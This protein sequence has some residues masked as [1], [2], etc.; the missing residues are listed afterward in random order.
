[1]SRKTNTL[2]VFFIYLSIHFYSSSVFAEKCRDSEPLTW[3]SWTGNVLNKTCKGYE[4]VNIPGVEGFIFKTDNFDSGTN[5]TLVTHA[6]NMNATSKSFSDKKIKIEVINT[7]AYPSET[8]TFD[9]QIA[10]RIESDFIFSKFKVN[11]TAVAQRYEYIQENDTLIAEFPVETTIDTDIEW[12]NELFLLSPEAQFLNFDVNVLSEMCS[13]NSEIDYGD[14]D[15][16]PRC[17][18]RLSITNSD[19]VFASKTYRVDYF[20]DKNN[21]FR[22][23]VREVDTICTPFLGCYTLPYYRGTLYL[24]AVEGSEQDDMDFTKLY[25]IDADG[26]RTDFGNSEVHQK[27]VDNLN[28][29]YDKRMKPTTPKLTTPGITSPD[30]TF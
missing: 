27:M 9:P 8:S 13:E 18:R 7:M 26:F 17:H 5:M 16:E 20:S 22:V 12:I 23:E 10:G 2:T 6:T 29:L 30:S 28:N 11:Y 24:D 1:M 3:G 15:D 4:F 14:D 25:W 19:L 21:G